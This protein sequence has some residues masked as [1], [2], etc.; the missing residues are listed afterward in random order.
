MKLVVSVFYLE[1]YEGND[2]CVYS[3]QMQFKKIIIIKY[4]WKFPYRM[5]AKSL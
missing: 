3:L 4:I 5:V 2:A 1:N